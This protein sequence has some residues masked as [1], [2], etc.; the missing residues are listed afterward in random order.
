MNLSVRVFE[1]PTYHHVKDGKLDLQAK[2]IF[3]EYVLGV[4]DYILRCLNLYLLRM[5]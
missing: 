4:K 2:D 1:G 5:I 3:L